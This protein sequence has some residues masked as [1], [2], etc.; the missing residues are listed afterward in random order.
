MVARQLCTLSFVTSAAAPGG[1][2]SDP[3]RHSQYCS[4][5]AHA[6]DWTDF[7]WFRKH[8][9]LTISL[10]IWLYRNCRDVWQQVPPAHRY[11]ASPPEKSCGLCARSTRR[12]CAYGQLFDVKHFR[13]EPLSTACGQRVSLEISRSEDSPIRGPIHLRLEVTSFRCHHAVK[14]SRR[15]P[16]MACRQTV[17]I[18]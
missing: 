4:C 1:L 16:C 7:L 6:L 17:A 9:D 2:S 14:L 8:Y 15:Q 10:M 3:A 5:I 12:G 13:N 18:V 11:R